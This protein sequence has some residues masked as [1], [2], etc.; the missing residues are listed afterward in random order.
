MPLFRHE[1]FVEELVADDLLLNH[2]LL[3]TARS[4]IMSHMHDIES[5]DHINNTNIRM[6]I[7]YC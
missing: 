2:L 3:K 5:H 1:C 7:V 4:Y 6:L